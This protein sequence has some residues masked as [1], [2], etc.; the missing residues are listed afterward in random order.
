MTRAVC[1]CFYFFALSATVLAID[2]PFMSPVVLPISDRSISLQRWV[3]VDPGKWL[4]VEFQGTHFFR[5]QPLFELCGNQ[6]G[7]AKV[8][9]SYISNPFGLTYFFTGDVSFL[10]QLVIRVPDVGGDVRL[11]VATPHDSLENAID[12][13]FVDGKA[14]T[15]F[16]IVRW[17]GAYAFVNHSFPKDTVLAWEAPWDTHTVFLDCDWDHPPSCRELDPVYSWNDQRLGTIRLPKEPKRLY[18]VLKAKSGE[19][20][21]NYRLELYVHDFQEFATIPIVLTTIVFLALALA[22]LVAGAGIAVFSMHKGNSETTRKIIVVT[23]ALSYAFWGSSY[24]STFLTWARIRNEKSTWS[25]S[26]RILVIALCVAET[27]VVTGCLIGLFVVLNDMYQSY[28]FFVYCCNITPVV[29]L[30]IAVGIIAICGL[31]IARIRLS[32][33]TA[34]ETSVLDDAYVQVSALKSKLLPN[35][36]IEVRHGADP[37]TKQQ[38]MAVWVIGGVHAAFSISIIWLSVALTAQEGGVTSMYVGLGIVG[39]AAMQMP[40]VVLGGIVRQLIAK[41]VMSTVEFWAF[42]VGDMVFLVCV[43]AY[44]SWRYDVQGI[45]IASKVLAGLDIPVV[46]YASLWYASL[47]S[48]AEDASDE[49]QEHVVADKSND[50]F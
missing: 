36:M 15:T 23:H 29:L 42:T 44:N 26:R 10:P 34:P 24:A 48:R 3:G 46:L 13:H 49:K 47:S 1:F 22:G 19:T 39:T 45:L 11:S 14:T 2:A 41:S 17:S 37:A 32:S 18:V 27:I 5:S 43:L 28:L 7:C 16:D 38:Q 40:I 50:G 9:E 4:V 21:L 35:D 8:P 20:R 31:G 33:V 6:S 25:P 12:L 30:L